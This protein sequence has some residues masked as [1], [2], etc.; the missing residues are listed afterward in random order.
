[1]RLWRSELDLTSLGWGPMGSCCEYSDELPV[2]TKSREYLS[3]LC[4][5][6]SIFSSILYIGVSKLVTLH[7]FC[8]EGFLLLLWLSQ[9]SVGQHDAAVWDMPNFRAYSSLFLDGSSWR[10]FGLCGTYGNSDP[11][12]N[13]AVCIS[14]FL[15]ISLDITVILASSQFLP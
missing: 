6:P 1:M 5:Y 13:I 14:T 15:S 11:G 9:C 7:I 10:I 12:N 2:F 8:W 3:Q 4:S